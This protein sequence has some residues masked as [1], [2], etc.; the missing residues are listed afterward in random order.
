M[1]VLLDE[2]V[3]VFIPTTPS[4]VNGFYFY[5]KKSE[6]IDLLSVDRA[7]KYIVSMGVASGDSRPA[8]Q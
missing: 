8:I 4:P 5:V 1:R 2:H 3:A 7:L 6:V